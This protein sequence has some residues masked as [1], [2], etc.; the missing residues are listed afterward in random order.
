MIRR[1][2][3]LMLIKGLGVGGAERL[4]EAALPHLDRDRYDYRVAYLL[5]WKTALVPAFVAADVPVHELAMRVAGDPRVLGRLVALLRR[6]RVDVV[7]AHLPI[8]GVL[9]RLAARLAGVRRVVY[10]EHNVPARYVF[11]TR[12][13]NRATYRMNDVVIAVSDE[14]RRAIEPYARGRPQI[15]TVHN[16]VD[17]SAL[18]AIPVEREAVRREFGFPADAPVVVTVGNLTPKKGHTYLLAAAA[19]VLAAHPGVRFVIVGQGPLA[20]DLRAEAS[21]HR[22]NGRL[23]FAGFR[24]DAV[25]IVAASDIF[26]LS[27]LHEG[28]PVSLL[29]AMALGKPS[30]VTRVGGIPEVADERSSVIIDP[31]NAEILAEAISTLLV[32]ADRRTQMGTAARGQAEARYGVPQMVRAVEQVYAS[33]LAGAPS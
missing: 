24:S 21:R 16:A 29:E 22:L 27:S 7:H 14:V 19:Q 15:V 6:E 2:R 25:R 17:A 13:L 33:L 11:P 10:T 26:V 30:V 23:V 3:I 20:D 8:A 32:S 9:G 12:L 1:A 28:L 18:A 5:P 31:Q 4:L